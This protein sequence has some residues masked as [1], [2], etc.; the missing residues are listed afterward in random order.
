MARIDENF[1]S[2]C[3]DILDH[4]TTTE[5]QEVRPHWPDGTPAYTIK[6]FGVVFRYNLQEEFPV[7]TLR[8]TPVKLSLIH[9]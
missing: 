9:I 1:I 5:G 2:M 8:K 6:K 7:L 3:T 4:G